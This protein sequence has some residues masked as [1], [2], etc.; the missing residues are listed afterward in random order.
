MTVTARRIA[1]ATLTAITTASIVTSC[2]PSSRTI[3]ID[4]TTITAE[5]ATTPEAQQTG[6]SGRADLPEGSGML[7]ELPSPQS[8]AVWMQDMR[9]PIDV[10]W[11]SDQQVAGIDTLT[12][13]KQ[14][15]ECPRISS[16]GTVDAI[17]EAPRGTFQGI[18][19]GTPVEW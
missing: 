19:P 14:G 16:P 10:V 11:I 2:A 3:T 7:F 17:L 8:T 13:C 1:I 18:P 15:E 9:F 6:L 4:G 12:P 5:L